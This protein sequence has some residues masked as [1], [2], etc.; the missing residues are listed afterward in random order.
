[1]ADAQQLLI[2]VESRGNEPC[3]WNGCYCV[4]S[5]GAVPVCIC[6]FSCCNACRTQASCCTQMHIPRTD[7]YTSSACALGLD[8]GTWMLCFWRFHTYSMTSQLAY[9]SVL[10]VC[11]CFDL[12]TDLFG[13]VLFWNMHRPTCVCS[14]P[15]LLIPIRGW[16]FDHFEVWS[17]F[18][19]C[20]RHAW[21]T[22]E[23]YYSLPACTMWYISWIYK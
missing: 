12:K 3:F 13:H 22:E 16:P 18:V 19:G 1:M 17:C 5:V 7:A 15:H 6:V 14:T 20:G 21:I 23:P 8:L 4:S 2:G 10:Q 9:R 11:G